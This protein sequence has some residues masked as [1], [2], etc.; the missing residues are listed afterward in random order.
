MKLQKLLFLHLSVMAL[1]FSQT[2]GVFAAT[3]EFIISK[4][5]TLYSY[6]Y[7]VANGTKIFDYITLRNFDT[8]RR[9]K[10]RLFGTINDLEGWF[11]FESSPIELDPLE[12]RNIT[13]SID[14]PVGVCGGIYNGYITT[15]LE[16]YSDTTA[17]AA[18]VAMK[19]AIAKP[20]NIEVSNNETCTTGNSIPGL[21][22]PISWTGGSAISIT[23]DSPVF[24]SAG[25]TTTGGS[26][27]GGGGG[28]SSGSSGACVLKDKKGKITKN[29]QIQIDA[30]L[31]AGYLEM[32]NKTKDSK[33]KFVSIFKDV[34]GRISERRI[35]ALYNMGII[36]KDSNKKFRPNKI[37]TRAELLKLIIHATNKNFSV[38]DL[39]IKFK[40][41]KYNSWYSKYVAYALNNKL[42]QGYPD[43]T[44]RPEGL[45]TKAESLQMIF[46][47][48]KVQ[49]INNLPFQYKDIPK[50]SWQRNIVNTSICLGIVKE[51]KN[52]KF[53]P[54]TIITRENAA[55]LIFEVMKVITDKAGK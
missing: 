21:G 5:N 44:F 40:D 37:I 35:A 24:V 25:G 19:S 48:F 50:T 36:S 32:I 33:N 53:F 47:A 28:S 17:G 30:K 18:S 2:S 45:V 15:I 38:S 52:G 22:Q 31:P 34:K 10:L 14:I 11:A 12:S 49:P 54:D 29:I 42:V 43:N 6:N 20:V 55:T 1:I 26:G 46:N 13:F 39:N 3:P 8:A 41:I 51:P 16:S 9:I 23:V 4:D 7:T 27:G